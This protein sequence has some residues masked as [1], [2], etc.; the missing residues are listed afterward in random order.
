[1]TYI[2]I[3]LWET[4]ALWC[5]CFYLVQ[6]PIRQKAFFVCQIVCVPHVDKHFQLGK[7]TGPTSFMFFLRSNW[8]DC[9]AGFEGCIGI[10]EASC[11]RWWYFQWLF[12]FQWVSCTRMDLIFPV[13]GII[14][15]RA[16]SQKSN[17]K[18]AKGRRE[19]L[20]YLAALKNNNMPYCGF[21]T[22]KAVCCA[23]HL[24]VQKHFLSEWPW[25]IHLH[26]FCDISESGDVYS[27]LWC[28]D[29]CRPP[30]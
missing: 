4:E 2:L 13:S 28:C 16:S 30:D 25:P 3:Y 5:Y 27:F 23:L 19:S 18:L 6:C 26:C 14:F 24:D 11:T 20:S 1:M 12:F 15:R 9:F 10:G 22:T 7:K 21:S 8:M 29:M 17:K